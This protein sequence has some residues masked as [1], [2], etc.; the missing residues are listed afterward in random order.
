M[1]GDMCH[2]DIKCIQIAHAVTTNMEQLKA[3][4]ARMWSNAP[5]W[6]KVTA[7]SV[8][9]TYVAASGYKVC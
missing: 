6:A 8:A 2:D 9:A 4:A 5:M 3:N 7:S 1:H